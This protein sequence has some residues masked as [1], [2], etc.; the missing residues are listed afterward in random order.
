MFI[1]SFFYIQSN[2]FSIGYE[3]DISRVINLNDNSNLIRFKINIAIILTKFSF[4]N[5][6]LWGHGDILKNFKYL[7]TYYVI[8]HNELLYTLLRF[9]L[10]RT[11]FFSYFIFSIYKKYINKS[12]L[13]YFISLLFY[14][15]FLWVDFLILPSLEIIFIFF[16]FSSSYFKPNERNNFSN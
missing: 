16:L 10:I 15:L 7:N 6:F 13:E 3:N 1:F 4:N 8:P 12:N 11:I 14:T 5:S 2:K 9:G